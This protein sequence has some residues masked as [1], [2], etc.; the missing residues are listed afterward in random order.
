M[1]VLTCGVLSLL[2]KCSGL[3]QLQRTALVYI[4]CML[5]TSSLNRLYDPSCIK[6]DLN[7]LHP[8]FTMRRVCSWWFKKLY[9][10]LHLAF[11]TKDQKLQICSHQTKASPQYDAP[12]TMF[13]SGIGGLW[14]FAAFY[15]QVKKFWFSLI[16]PQHFLPSFSN[17]STT[18]WLWVCKKKIK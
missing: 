10:F 16:R 17:S 13:H 1:P 8:R 15:G 18:L 12:T 3:L 4:L 7:E 6:M 11:Y 2:L 5:K 14:R 9:I